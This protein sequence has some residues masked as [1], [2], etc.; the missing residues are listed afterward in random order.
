MKILIVFI[1]LITTAYAQDTVIYQTYPGTDIRDYSAPSM[2]IERDGVQ[3]NGIGYQTHPGTTVRD[4]S[5]P[6]IIIERNHGRF[7]NNQHRINQ[8]MQQ[9]MPYVWPAQD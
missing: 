5:K 6:G 8:P 1:A 9:V 2:V 3:G 4:Y 7:I